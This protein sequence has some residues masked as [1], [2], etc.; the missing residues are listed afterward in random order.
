MPG[1][2]PTNELV[3]G[4][5]K[6]LRL[7]C[8]SFAW[9]RLLP[10]A[11]A[12]II[13]GNHQSQ[14]VELAIKEVQLPPLR[15][16]GQLAKAHSQGMEFVGGS[17]LVTARRDDVLPKRAL[18]LR[19]AAAAEDWDVWDI[20]PLD[21]Q[22]EV[23]TLDHPGGMQSDGTRVWIPL[24]ESRRN[25]RSIIRAFPLKDLVAGRPLEPELQFSVNDHIGA[26][27]VSVEH[28][29]LLGA[30]W[31]TEKVYVW[32]FE[33]NLQRTL[34]SFELK[35]RGLG[36]A[37]AE[38]RNG[39]AVQDW[40]LVG[41][42]LFASGLLRT[43]GD[44]A[45]STESRLSCFTN[46]LEAGFQ[47]WTVKL[48]LVNGTQLAREAMTISGSVLHFLPED[49]GATNRMFRVSQTNWFTDLHR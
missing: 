19:T 16:Q 7:V 37:S 21:A 6:G 1:V 48:P 27:A 46:F 2:T 28:Q 24:A 3:N 38:G 39:L 10:E 13:C 41:D 5:V 29:W 26:V 47:R 45:G 25:G 23:T 12:A 40:K 32:N 43:F 8:L 20:T 15:M 36:V 34:T 44:S 22:G 42:G 11:L 35:T 49:L 4:W 30:N 9:K 33:G 17:I 18:L 14:A 31:D